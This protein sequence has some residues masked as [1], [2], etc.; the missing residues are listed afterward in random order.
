MTDTKLNKFLKAR[1]D[2]ADFED[3]LDQLRDRLGELNKAWTQKHN[4]GDDSDLA[5]LNEKIR[6]IHDQIYALKIYQS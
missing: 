5:A 2:E 6:N 4:A 1:Q 3:A